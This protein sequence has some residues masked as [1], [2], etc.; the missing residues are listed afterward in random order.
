MDGARK[1]NAK[2]NQ[3]V[4]ERQI[5]YDFTQVQLKKQNKWA[6][7]GKRETKEE[8]DSSLLRANTVTKGER[9]GTWMKQGLRIKAYT[10]REEHWVWCMEVNHFSVHL[11]LI[12]HWMLTLLELKLKLR[13][14][15]EVGLLSWESWRGSE[16]FNQ[17]VN[18]IRRGCDH[19]G[20]HVENKLETGMRVV[21]RPGNEGD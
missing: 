1:Y 2:R 8:T 15:K 16:D 18:R 6:K 9:A 20:C 4:R 3:S 11:K 5:P 21:G 10:C 7:G 12:Q 17:D 14:E 19:S 13:K